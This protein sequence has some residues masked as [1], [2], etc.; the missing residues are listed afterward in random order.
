MVGALWCC[1]CRWNHRPDQKHRWVRSW[2]RYRM[3]RLRGR[4]DGL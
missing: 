4:R 2:L 1:D 3:R